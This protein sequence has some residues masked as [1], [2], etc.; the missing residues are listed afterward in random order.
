MRITKEQIGAVKL[1]SD[2]FPDS[3]VPQ[4]KRDA[5]FCA[6]WLQAAYGASTGFWGGK[7]WEGTYRSQFDT[8]RL[9][10]VGKQP[11]TP[12]ISRYSLAKGDTSKTGDGGLLIT[13][14]PTILS[15]LPGMLGRVRTTVTSYP[16]VPQVR[17][18]DPVSRSERQN[19]FYSKLVDITMRKQVMQ[20]EAAVGAMRDMSEEPENESE[21]NLFMESG[22]FKEAAA[23]LFENV[24]TT[25]FEQSSY[26]QW[27][28][29]E[30]VRLDLIPCGMGAVGVTPREDG[31]VDTRR[32]PPESLMLPYSDKMDFRDVRW[33]G[34][35]RG[36]STD[37]LAREANLSEPELKEC[38]E[39]YARSTALATGMSDFWW[40][41]KGAAAKGEVP[42]L[43]F[44]FIAS[45][46]IDYKVTEKEG[47]KSYHTIDPS[48]LVDDSEAPEGLS[49]VSKNGLAVY[50]ISWVIGSDIYWNAGLL[51]CQPAIVP[52]N[53][54]LPIQVVMPENYGLA[55]LSLVEQA[56][57][58]V[59][60]LQLSWLRFQNIID[61]NGPPILVYVRKL[62][63]Y[64]AGGDKI[65]TDEVLKEMRASGTLGI[66]IPEDFYSN[67][68]GTGAP[69]F[70]LDI[71]NAGASLESELLIMSNLMGM[72][73]RVTGF[74]E[75]S[76]GGPV[77]ERKGK[78]VAMMEQRSTVD[79]MKPLV[80]SMERLAVNI[81]HPLI[82]Y[83]LGAV[84][85]KNPR[86]TAYWEGV[87]GEEAVQALKGIALDE[88]GKGAAV[89]ESIGLSVIP[90]PDPQEVQDIREAIMTAMTGRDGKMALMTLADKLVVESYLKTG[91]IKMAQMY[92][93]RVERKRMK[94]AAK[95]AEAQ[96]KAQHAQAME[97]KNAD[98]EMMK[99]QMGIKTEADAG[100]IAA[101]NQ[102]KMEFLQLKD[103]LDKEN[104]QLKS[105]LDANQ[106][107]LIASVDTKMKAF[108]TELEATLERQNESAAI[109]ETGAQQR[110]TQ[111]QAPVQ[112][113]G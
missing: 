51:P 83:I 9:Y 34:A 62:L 94:D 52:G 53:P 78:A 92:M 42:V 37:E 61:K 46:D 95:Q 65:K 98:I 21:L 7:T 23:S 93:L 26:D 40:D 31:G 27:V 4:S 97:M 66:D 81:A 10:A 82:G 54:F 101:S 13:A 44:Y 33:T 70:P 30:I 39:K 104:M 2:Q 110:L 87:L 35:F 84:T 69:V 112:S 77:D 15:I 5:A 38:Q 20:M 55:F 22:L 76:A 100:K 41:N 11:E 73:M 111:A 19:T 3:N 12:Y 88:N 50:G 63:A 67:F 8:L 28:R 17:A 75:I 107:E 59:D 45:R 99:L 72:L 25:G 109:R 32:Y 103:Q 6:A 56:A 16:T 71:N 58:I 14:D 29:D 105:S 57:P 89:L 18:N 47:K 24:L 36:M 1:A 90:Y 68:G 85:S 64:V 106:Q 43:D 91:R 49:R 74:N 80:K 108:L 60:Q 102:A 79:A 48:K 86:K 113:K 96:S